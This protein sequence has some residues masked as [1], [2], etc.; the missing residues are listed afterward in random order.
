MKRKMSI[1][2][3]KINKLNFILFILLL[4]FCS[5]GYFYNLFHSWAANASLYPLLTGLILIFI[6]FLINGKVYTNKNLNYLLIF[7]F[8]ALIG[9]FIMSLII[10]NFGHMSYENSEELYIGAIKRLITF[11]IIFLTVYYTAFC[12]INSNP[13]FIL[14]VLYFSFILVLV[15]GYIQLLAILF[16][17]S[18]WYKIYMLIQHYV[19]FGWIGLN[20]EW[21]KIPQIYQYGGRIILTTQEPSIAGYLI[22]T[23]YY[24]FLLSSLITNYSIYK[25]KPFGKSLEFILFISS[26][27]LIFF[28]FST[29]FYVIFIILILSAVYLYF[30]NPSTKKIIRFF[31]YFIVFIVILLILYSNL[32]KD[33][34]NNI[35]QVFEKILMKGQGA[36][37]SQTRYGFMYAGV[38]EFLHYPIFGVG[39]SNSKYVFANYIPTWAYNSE[40]IYYLSTGKALG[41]KGFWSWL[42]GETGIFGT[43]AFILFLFSLIKRY[44]SKAYLVSR[45][46]I[47]LRYVFLLFLISFF[48]QGFNSAALFFIWQWTLFGLFIGFTRRKHEFLH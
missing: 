10:G 46:K 25:I 36:G 19:N 34:I 39:V 4:P 26:L 42:F 33:Y 23:L 17:F 48:L 13:K 31:L 45:D 21:N 15:Y 29:S 8:V 47:Y 16:P 12:T 1:S 32:P 7:S 2:L 18:Y 3:E 30:K 38:I 11:S 37:S 20:E 44:F 35:S 28:T 27:P 40:V 9:T 14:K 5:L 6:K 41:P 43:S 24:P 22:S